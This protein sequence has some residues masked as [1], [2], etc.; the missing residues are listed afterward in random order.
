MFVQIALQSE[1]LSTSLADVGFHVGVRLYVRTEVGL[2]CE[3]FGTDWTPKRTFAGVGAHVALK[4]PRSG[5]GLAAVGAPAAL[6]VRA[7]VHRVRRHR[8]VDLVAFG[9][10]ARLWNRHW[11]KP[12][13]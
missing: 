9:T 5:E 2:V 13:A 4:K 8:D 12:V 10:F 1:G 11:C 3:C 7:H 6:G